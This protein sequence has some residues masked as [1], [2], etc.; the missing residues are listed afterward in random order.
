M[1]QDR[2]DPES[3]RGADDDLKM[4][5]TGHPEG[6]ADLVDL[7]RLRE[8]CQFARPAEPDEDAWQEVRTRIALAVP[9]VRPQ[10]RRSPRPVWALASAAAAAVLGAILLLRSGW[11]AGPKPPAAPADE[12]AYPVAEA[13][14]VTIISMDARDVAALV[15]GEPPITGELVFAQPDDVRVIKCERCPRSGNIAQLAPGEVPMMVIA[16]TDDANDE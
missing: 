13:E 16:R 9:A 2:S 10:P 14:D 7:Q 6:H 4:W 5:L 1:S 3:R 12:E 11:I 8:L 15:V